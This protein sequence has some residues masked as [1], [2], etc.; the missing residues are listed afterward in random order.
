MATPDAKAHLHEHGWVRIPGVISKE[1]AAAALDKLWQAKE[2]YEKDGMPAHLSFLDPNAS[3]VRVF[4]LM[5]YEEIFRDLI[6]NPT[7]IEMVKAVLGENFII[8]NFT[9]NVARPGSES[10]RAQHPYA[11]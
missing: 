2:K 7:A 1:D 6:A 5:A 10:V 9:A 11:H 3:N 4:Y 8:S